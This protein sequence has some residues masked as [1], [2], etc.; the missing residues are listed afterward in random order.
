MYPK[1][2]MC[3][4]SV[5]VSYQNPTRSNR[6]RDTLNLG[7]LPG[8]GGLPYLALLTYGYLPLNR[9]WFSG[10]WGYIMNTLR[11]KIM[12]RAALED[13]QSDTSDEWRGV[14]CQWSTY[15]LLYYQALSESCGHPVLSWL[16][17]QF[18]SLFRVKSSLPFKEN[19]ALFKKYSAERTDYK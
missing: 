7:V 8:G 13:A 1:P 9:V 16:L 15:H 17:L 2:W 6:R 19:K 14:H 5:R 12:K 10:S 4:R 3:S 18:S 11:K